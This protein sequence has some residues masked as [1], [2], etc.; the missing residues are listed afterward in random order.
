LN[1]DTY[2]CKKTKD[3]RDKIHEELRVD[4]VERKFT[5]YKQKWLNNV[6]RMEDVRYTKQLLDYRPIGRR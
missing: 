4:P 3:S 6:S 2:E 5:Q 1:V